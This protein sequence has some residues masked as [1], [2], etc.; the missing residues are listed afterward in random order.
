MGE[1]MGELGLGAKLERG[2]R[3]LRGWK[4]VWSTE[5]V[6]GSVSGVVEVAERY[7]C[8]LEKSRTGRSWRVLCPSVNP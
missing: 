4:R 6:A 7:L 1:G 5:R 3:G 2:L 8:L